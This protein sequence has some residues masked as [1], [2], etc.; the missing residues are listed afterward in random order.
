M[1][2]RVHIVVRGVVQGVGF[3]MYT[4]LEANRLGLRGYVRNLPDGAVEIVAEGPADAIER[5]IAW[6]KHGPPAASVEDVNVEYAEPN[7]EFVEFGIR[8]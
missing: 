1:T 6:A 5:L 3:R 7:G 2:K 8:H 4:E